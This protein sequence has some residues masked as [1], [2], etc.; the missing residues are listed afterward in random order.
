MTLPAR[1]RRQRRI[2]HGRVA[3]LLLASVS[4]RVVLAAPPQLFA[5]PAHQG[6]ATAR[7][8][9]LVLLAHPWLLQLDH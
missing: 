8:D 3:L 6:L 1:T 7:P 2:Q 5:Q 9:E 4:A